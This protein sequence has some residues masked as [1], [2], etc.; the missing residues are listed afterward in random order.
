VA[1]GKTSRVLVVEQL[2]VLAAEIKEIADAV[3]RA[4]TDRL[5]VNGRFLA[6]K[7]GREALDVENPARQA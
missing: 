7:F 2:D 5:I 4:D 1:N 6:T 3:N